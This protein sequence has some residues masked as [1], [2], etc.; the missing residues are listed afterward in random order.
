MQ[1]TFSQFN[2]LFQ[3]NVRNAVLLFSCLLFLNKG[4]VIFSHRSGLCTEH[5]LSPGA[6][7]SNGAAT[8]H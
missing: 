7:E 2:N 5:N 1:L 4:A 8:Y 6:P 3:N